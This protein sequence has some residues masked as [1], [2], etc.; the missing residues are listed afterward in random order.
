MAT[1]FQAKGPSGSV[2]PRT[3]LLLLFNSKDTGHSAKDT[4]GDLQGGIQRPFCYHTSQ[5]GADQH[6]RVPEGVGWTW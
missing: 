6:H 2:G 4:G 1:L 5:T 3:H